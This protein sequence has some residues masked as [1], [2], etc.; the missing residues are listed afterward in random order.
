MKI[1]NSN[2]ENCYTM[3]KLFTIILAFILFAGAYQAFGSKDIEKSNPNQIEKSSGIITNVVVT[4][5][6]CHGDCTGCIEINTS[7]NTGIVLYS[8]NGGSTW[9]SNPTY[10]GLCA[11]EYIIKVKDDNGEVS[12]GGFY[13]TEP[14]PITF[15]TNVSPVYCNGDSNG[16]IEVTNINGGSGSYMYSNDGGTTWNSSSYFCGLPAGDYDIC[17]KDDNDCQSTVTTVTITEPQAISF[18]PVV[19]QNVTC[20]GGADGEIEVTNVSGGTPPYEYSDDGG[21]TYQI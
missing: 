16:C 6:L 9:S 8:I 7:G 4:S 13:I 15:S 14:S 3:R 21:A 5:I 17:L 2:F 20:N 11:G 12:V 19:N 1:S 10:C 18:N